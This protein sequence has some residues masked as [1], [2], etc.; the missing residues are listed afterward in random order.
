MQWTGERLGVA[1]KTQVSED[2][3]KLDL[4]TES[5]KEGVEKLSVSLEDYTKTLDKRSSQDKKVSAMSM[6]AKAMIQQGHFHGDSSP[7][8]MTLLRIGETE[9]KLKGFQEEFVPFSY[10]SHLEGL[11]CLGGDGEKRASSRRDGFACV[12]ERLRC[13]EEKTRESKT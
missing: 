1:D 4:E 3:Q 11:K 8:G 10:L 2:F 12:N 13:F 9:D 5:R 6:L 7:I